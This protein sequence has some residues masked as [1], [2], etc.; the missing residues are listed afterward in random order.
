MIKYDSLLFFLNC[1]FLGNQTWFADTFSQ[2]RVYCEKKLDYCIQG[3]GHSEVSKCQ[4]L[5]RSY[6]LNHLAF[7]PQTNIVMQYHKLECHAKRLI[8]YFQ[9]QGH[10]KGSYDQNMTVSTISAELLILLL[11]NLV[12]WYI[13]ISQNVLWRN[14]NCCVQGQGH[15]KISKCQ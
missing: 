9:G 8:C 4:C 7:C 14:F 10:S 6:L 13:I 12:C 3:Q 2:A 5:S 15:S 1:W 11:S